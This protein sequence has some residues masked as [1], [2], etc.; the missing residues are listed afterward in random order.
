M[1]APLKAYLIDPFAMTI[2][3]V[4]RTAAPGNDSLR[5]IYKLI[6]CD[7]ITAVRPENAKDDVMY[8][9]DEGLFKSE[10]AYFMC[11]LWPY[12]AIAGR[13]LWVGTKANGNDASPKV[14]LEYV[15]AHIVW[16]LNERV[17]ANDDYGN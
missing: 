13:A 16:Q 12:Q 3:E 14:T 15:Q 8:V 1:R 11:R 10:Q 4:E 6:D 5:E 2:T 17:G 9:D 7:T